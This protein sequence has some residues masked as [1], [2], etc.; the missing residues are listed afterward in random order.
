[1]PRLSERKRQ[2]KRALEGLRRG[3]LIELIR[4]TYG[5]RTNCS[6]KIGAVCKILK[7]DRTQRDLQ[8]LIQDVSHPLKVEWTSV[9]DVEPCPDH[10]TEAMFKNEADELTG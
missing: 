2:I 9:L 1:M 3:Q 5:L 7:I 10:W 4:D 6:P 8:L